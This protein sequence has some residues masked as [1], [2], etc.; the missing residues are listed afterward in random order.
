[1]TLPPRCPKPVLWRSKSTT[2]EVFAEG[3][4]PPKNQTNLKNQA[5]AKRKRFSKTTF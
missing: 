5:Y 3:V 4:A 2:E 1:M